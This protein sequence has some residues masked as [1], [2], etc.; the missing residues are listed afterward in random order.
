[1]RNA[2]KVAGLLVCLSVLLLQPQAAPAN[3]FAGAAGWVVGWAR[4]YLLGKAA[5]HVWD[6]ATGKPDVEQLQRRLAHVEREVERASRSAAV[7]APIRDLRRQITPDTSYAEYSRLAKK[8]LDD[9]NA[10]L[11]KLEREVQVLE[12]RVNQHDATLDDLKQWKEEE[13]R[14]RKAREQAIE[15]DVRILQLLLEQNSRR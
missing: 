10:R 4:D 1:M 12:Q 13:Q 5:D 9:V 6:S 14:K 15:N 11:E 3:P 2:T 7:A 8:A